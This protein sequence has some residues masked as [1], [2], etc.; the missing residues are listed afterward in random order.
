MPSTLRLF[1]PV[2]LAILAA[3]PIAA[4]SL[5]RLARR[6]PAC[7]RAVR[8]TFGALL[9]ANELYWNFYR[10]RTEGWRFPEGLPLQLCDFSIWMAICAALT[11]A[12]WAVEAAYLAGVAGGGMAVLTPDLWAPLCSYP[13]IYFFFA[14]GGLIVVSL[15]L[16][17]SGMARLRPGAVWRVFGIVN[18]FGLFAGIFNLVFHTNY[19]YLCRKP[20][21]ASA[22]DALGSWPF[23]LLAGEAVA[24]LLFWLLWLPFRRAR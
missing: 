15:T 3:I 22:L 10:V 14:H 12:P 5:S 11:L 21:S 18:A 6:S 19:M 8:L 17:W 4:W 7:G 9:L 2:H 13:T 1:S 24:L 16:L 20:Q 23:Y